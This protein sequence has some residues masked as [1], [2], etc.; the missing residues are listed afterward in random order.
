MN[1]NPNGDLLPCPNYIDI[2]KN[3]PNIFDSN[4][5]D[6]ITKNN[7]II[8]KSNICSCYENIPKVNLKHLHLSKLNFSELLKFKG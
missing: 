3:P 1:I 4:I 7:K 8:C 5:S 2:L 6:I